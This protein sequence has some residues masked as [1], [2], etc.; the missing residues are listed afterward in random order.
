MQKLRVWSAV[1]RYV[2]TQGKVRTLA[3]DL[4]SKGAE[5]KLSEN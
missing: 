1:L 3:T 5:G 2:S 4:N